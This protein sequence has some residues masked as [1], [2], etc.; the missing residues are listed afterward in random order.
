[1][2]TKLKRW[3]GWDSVRRLVRRFQCAWQGHTPPPWGEECMHCG[4]IVEYG[5]SGVR[6]EIRYWWMYQAPSWLRPLRWVKKCRDCGKR[7][8]KHT[9]DC[10]PF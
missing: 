6:Q 7:F 2:K 5:W 10:P 4:E 9:D 1:M 8:G 3:T